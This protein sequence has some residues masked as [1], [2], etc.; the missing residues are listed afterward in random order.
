MV[1]MEHESATYRE[2]LAQ[3]QRKMDIFQGNVNTT[4]KYI[5]AQKATT[6]TLVNPATAMVIGAT[7]V[8]TTYID[9]VVNTLIQLVVSQPIFY[10]SPSRH[11]VSYPWGLPPNFAPQFAKGNAFMPYRPFAMHPANGN[12][13]AHPQGMTTHSLQMVGADNYEINLERA[14]QTFIPVTVETPDNNKDEYKGPCLNFHVPPQATQ[15]TVQNLNQG[16][17]M[18]QGIV[19]IPKH[20]IDKEDSTQLTPFGP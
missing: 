5:L 19:Q 14:L 1:D 16:V 3:F 2:S 13:V 10:P 12:Y 11:D 9:N 17:L 8:V 4:L 7:V 18:M 20:R 15:L 6:S